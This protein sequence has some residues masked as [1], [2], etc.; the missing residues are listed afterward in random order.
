MSGIGGLVSTMPRSYR[1]ASTGPRHAKKSR[2]RL[3][4][5][6]RGGNWMGV[7]Y[8]SYA[9]HDRCTRAKIAAGGDSAAYKAERAAIIAAR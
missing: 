4:A 5:R 2:K 3:N 8:L 7:P 9:E 1:P 6:V